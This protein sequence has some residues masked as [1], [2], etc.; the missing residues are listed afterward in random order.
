MSLSKN[1]IL[2]VWTKGKKCNCNLNGCADSHKSCNLCGKTLVKGAH[3]SSQPTSKNA[4]SVD[5]IKP[6]A[7]GGSDSTDNLQ[8]TCVSCNSK[9]ADN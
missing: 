1:K 6:R 7:K 4:W 8:L 9:K 3:V 5:H 2:E